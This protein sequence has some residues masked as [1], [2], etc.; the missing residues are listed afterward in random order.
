M[1]SMFA[2][3]DGQETAREYFCHICFES[4]SVSLG[5]TLKC[6]HTFCAE[7]LLRYLDVKISEGD[8]HP[9][10]FHPI[11]KPM[12]PSSEPSAAGAQNVVP[13]P[14]PQNN[15]KPD[16]STGYN[17]SSNMSIYSAMTFLGLNG[18]SN[19]VSEGKYFADPPTDTHGTEILDKA[20]IVNIEPDA[21]SS[22]SSSV[23]TEPLSS[24]KEGFA[25][26]S[27]VD[28]M[29]ID[30]TEHSNLCRSLYL[31]NEPGSRPPVDHSSGVGNQ[32]K[33]SVCVSA[34][35]NSTM[36][37]SAPVS[38]T[39]RD[40]AANDESPP[41]QSN[42][43]GNPVP[44]T[45]AGAKDICNVEFSSE[46][47]MS[48]IESDDELVDKYKYFQFTKQNPDAR[49]CPRCKAL[50]MGSAVTPSMTCGSCGCVYCFFH[51]GAH[52]NR[53][54]EEYEKSIAPEV[55]SISIRRATVSIRWKA[56]CV[57]VHMLRVRA[58]VYVCNI[59]ISLCFCLL[60]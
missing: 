58:N 27:A 50:Q 2:D 55:V 22:T 35:F 10:C 42:P 4:Q 6:G 40:A 51:S 1:N 25:L 28:P 12:A 43:S 26:N 14:L 16:D 9:K 21:V 39:V 17:A 13:A 23:V 11:E 5:K 8:V 24:R 45:A 54:C 37:A 34:A 59:V 60:G 31:L 38:T 44:D 56:A 19:T 3:A 30:E 49:E 57:C 46:E 48:I 32:D 36:S 7:C 47:I 18:L 20:D 53:T 33:G 52:P 41:P 29:S 15:W